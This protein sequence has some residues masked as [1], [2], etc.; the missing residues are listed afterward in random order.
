[1]GPPARRQ[2]AL[3]T[4]SDGTLVALS[5]IGAGAAA[6]SAAAL[7]EAGATALVSW[8]L[9]GGLDP[10]LTAGTICLPSAVLTPAGAEFKTDGHWRELFLAA[11]ASRRPVA[12][13]PI[14]TNATAL[15][16][17]AG[18]AAAFRA[19]GAV[20]VDME[21]VAVAAIA[22]QH[23]IPFL[24]VRVIVDTAADT[25]PRSV[26]AATQGGQLRIGRLLQGLA[27]SPGDIPALLRLARRYGAAKRAL[28][29]V[30]RTG[31]LAP[32]AFGAAATRRIA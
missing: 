14:L 13:G 22:A 10:A 29:A 7:V 28:V 6:T 26:L 30:A 25:L 21:S 11:I 15:D 1:M 23:R 8:G 18:K 12:G 20:A 24:A 27:Q 9:A 32:V 17:V 31:A 19:T 16:D 5:G 4:L 2:G 3:A